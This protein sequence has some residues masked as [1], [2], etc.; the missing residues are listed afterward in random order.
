V[1]IIDQKTIDCFVI[2]NNKK[3]HIPLCNN[4]LIYNTLKPK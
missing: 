2:K 4:P 1:L 3:M